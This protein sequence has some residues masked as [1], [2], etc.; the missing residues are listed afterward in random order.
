MPQYVTHRGQQLDR[1]VNETCGRSDALREGGMPQYVSHKGQQLGRK[2]NETW[3][4]SDALGE[5]GMPQYAMANKQICK[6]PPNHCTLKYAHP[7]CNENV[8]PQI[9]KA[10][11]DHV[12]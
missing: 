10:K 7:S 12:S 3:G 8:Q 5:G 11:Q 4:R 2:V 6:M 1:K 9:G